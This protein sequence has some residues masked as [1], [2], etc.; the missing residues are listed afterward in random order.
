MSDI[1]RVFIYWDNSNLFIGARGLARE[2]EGGDAYYR[3]RLEFANLLRLAHADRPVAHA[4]AV[5]SV[6]P[7]LRAVWNRLEGTGVSVEL[8]ERGESSGRE[9]AVDNALQTRMLR[10]LIDNNGDPG[11]V[12]LMTGDGAGFYDGVGFH[13]DIARMHARGWRVE[14]LAWADSCNRRMRRWVEENGL[15]VSLDD[16]YDAVTFLTEA[17]PGG[18]YAL[19]RDAGALELG[20]RFGGEG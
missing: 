12:V 9:Q 15:F 18:R 17:L 2:R 8:F 13:A 11:T 20:A 5:G 19:P 14:V 16:Y 4:Y 6:P 7:E 10:D 1:N 3:V